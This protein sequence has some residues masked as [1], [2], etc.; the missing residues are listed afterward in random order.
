M[1]IRAACLDQAL[2]GLPEPR[3]TFAL[4]IDVPLYASVHTRCAELGPPAL[5]VV[6]LAR[7]LGPTE[8]GSEALEGLESLMTALQPGWRERV[9]G[10]RFLPELTVMHDAPQAAH[11]GAAGRFPVEV[12]DVPG[13]FVVGDWVGGEGMLADAVLASAEHAAATLLARPSLRAAA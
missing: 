12:A 5:A 10:R 7:Y 3:R 1:P 9:V 2:S 8:A 6:H 13:A 11:G 4:G